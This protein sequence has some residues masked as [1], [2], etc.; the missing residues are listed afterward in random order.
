VHTDTRPE[1]QNVGAGAKTGGGTM[2]LLLPSG[3]AIDV[4]LLASTPLPKSYG[5]PARAP[6]APPPVNVAVSTPAP[7][8]QP[9]APAPSAAEQALLEQQKASQQ[10]DQKDQQNRQRVA[11]LTSQAL[12]TND[13]QQQMSLYGQVIQ[14]DPSNAAAIQGYKEAQGKVQAQQAAQQQAASAQAQEQQQQ[15]TREQTTNRQLGKARTAFLN[16]H[17]AEASAALSVAERVSPGNPL[18]RELRSRI[19]S[20]QAV[21]SRLYM[22][23]SGAGLLALVGAFAVWRRRRKQ[24][25]FPVLEIVRGFDQGQTF[26]IDKDLVRI[27]AVPGNGAQKNDIVLHDVEHALS[28]FHCEVARRNGD[29]YITDLSSSNGTRVDGTPLRPG[30]PERLRKGSTISL[31]NTID[32]RFGYDRRAGKST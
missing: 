21:R 23:G 7:V 6:A 22:L 14:I 16:G 13:P 15:Q 9:A 27:G 3:D 12:A 26:P 19:S 5:L 1:G 32:L 17:L 8:P 18:V 24:Q 28:R 11:A 10:K 31:A 25:R 30:Q 4:K 20:A 2:T 29:L